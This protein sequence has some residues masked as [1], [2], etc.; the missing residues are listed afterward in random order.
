MPLCGL[1]RAALWNSFIGALAL[2]LA[3]CGP[4]APDNPNVG[5]NIAPAFYE[6]DDKLLL[7]IGQGPSPDRKDSGSTGQIAYLNR[8]RSL[9]TLM[10]VPAGATGVYPCGSSAVSPDQRY[11]TFFVHAPRA[12]IDGGTLYQV[13]GSGEPQ[14]VGDA[15][16]LSCVG[17][18][19][20]YAPSVEG[21]A[22][23][24][25]SY[26]Q[27]TN[28]TQEYARGTLRIANPAS[29]EQPLHSSD[30]VTNV[31]LSA[32]EA[33]YVSLYTNASNQV[34][35][36]GVFTWNGSAERE[37]ATLF[38]TTGCRFTSGQVA[39]TSASQITV[40]MGQRCGGSVSQW[41]FYVVDRESGAYTLAL[42]GQQPNSFFPYTRSNNVIPTTQDG[43]VIFTPTDGLAVNTTGLTAVDVNDVAANTVLVQRGAI[44]A[45]TN[46]SSNNFF[47]P[48]NAPM[49][50]SPD[51]R[52]LALTVNAPSQP[53]ALAVVDLQS[54]TVAPIRVSVGS[55]GESVPMMGFNADSSRLYFLSGGTG[56]RDNSLQWLDLNSEST[57]RIAR[58]QFGPGVIAPGGQMIALLAYRQTQEAR[59][60][61]YVDLISIN[62]A[63]ETI[64]LYSGSVRGEDG[65]Y[66]PRQF[67]YPL[68]WR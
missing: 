62:D 32:S 59:P 18:S 55:T 30:N 68:A 13:S 7:W 46:P 39:P 60:R 45:R 4:A 54:P 25:L 34:D 52:W 44:M 6:A 66:S 38:P 27:Y 1:L 47:L 40:I 65:G 11:F 67:A 5:Q 19:L 10:E 48:E 56:G 51:G 64:T 63:G 26:I 28:V 22:S 43:V 37:V 9:Q 29:L 53:P 17:R 42:S 15:H 3:G 41:Q 58:G 31:Y 36:A 12:G 8:D 50:V 2:L 35:E 21:Q 33:L 20:Q 14:T 16:A 23:R 61:P 24:W 49:N 57:N